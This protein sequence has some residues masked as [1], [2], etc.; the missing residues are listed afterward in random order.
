MPRRWLSLPIL[1]N[2]MLLGAG[3]VVNGDISNFSLPPQQIG[4]LSVNVHDWK[5]FIILERVQTPPALGY[6]SLSWFIVLDH[7]PTK[8][9]C[10]FCE[11]PRQSKVGLFFLSSRSIAA[12][13]RFLRFSKTVCSVF[14]KTLTVFPAALVV[15]LS[16]SLL[17]FSVSLSATVS[18]P[19]PVWLPPAPPLLWLI[20]SPFSLITTGP[21]L[22]PLLWDRRWAKLEKQ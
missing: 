2:S 13:T 4:T 21:M 17:L 14:L 1:E 7:N 5:W 12:I 11:R 15:L 10:V 19:R 20:V 22:F 8:C 18:L 6:A 16:L 9:V 3:W